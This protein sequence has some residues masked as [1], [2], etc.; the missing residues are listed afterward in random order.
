MN[1]TLP[2]SNKVPTVI[3]NDDFLE[4]GCSDGDA[5]MNLKF[6]TYELDFS[7]P[8]VNPH[9]EQCEMCGD[10][11][12][13]AGTGI[14]ELTIKDGNKCIFN[15]NFNKHWVLFL[16]INKNSGNKMPMY[17]I[18]IDIYDQDNYD[19]DGE[20]CEICEGNEFHF[21]LTSVVDS[22]TFYLYQPRRKEYGQHPPNPKEILDNNVLEELK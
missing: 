10:P 11:V 17:T 6:E 18:Y 7:Y 15:M 9:E 1:I 22:Y 13:M 16:T 2:E 20:G 21:T 19:T 14:P 12:T 4:M 8:I 5:L 3:D